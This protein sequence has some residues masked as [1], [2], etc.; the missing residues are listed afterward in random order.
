M[1]AAFRAED[2]VKMR[3]QLEAAGWCPCTVD[4]YLVDWCRAACVEVRTLEPAVKVSGLVGAGPVVVVP[5][6]AAEVVRGLRPPS[7]TD[8]MSNRR[9]MA[10]ARAAVQDAQAILYRANTDAAFRASVLVACTLIGRDTWPTIAALAREA[11]YEH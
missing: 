7:P 6:W 10:A 8:G 3:E 5:M 1:D 11:R 9:V 4:A 2:A